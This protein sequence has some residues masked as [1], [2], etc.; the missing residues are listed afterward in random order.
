MGFKNPMSKSNLYKAP[1]F[2]IAIPHFNMDT[3]FYHITTIVITNSFISDWY[4]P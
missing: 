2:K 1:K 4:K 3:K